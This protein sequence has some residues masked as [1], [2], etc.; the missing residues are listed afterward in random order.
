MVVRRLNAG[1]SVEPA[2]CGRLGTDEEIGSVMC[3]SFGPSLRT[4]K[5]FLA[6]VNPAPRLLYR[7]SLC[8]RSCVTLHNTRPP[9]CSLGYA[10]EGTNVV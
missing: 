7:S 5:T 1:E 3:I 4:V 8:K 9:P 10:M 6:P 2:M